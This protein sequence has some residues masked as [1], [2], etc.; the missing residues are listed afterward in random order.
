MAFAMVSI[1]MGA[2]CALRHHKV[3]ALL[4]LSTF[5][6]VGIVLSEIICQSRPW[7]IATEALMAISAVQLAYVGIT[8]PLHLFRSTRSMFPSVQAAIGSQL[9]SELEVRDILPLELSL[10][11]AQLRA[12][13]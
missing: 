9:R 1:A 8:L 2:V 11:A 6:A 12:A 13:D 3:F 4:L 5:L 10:F 7:L